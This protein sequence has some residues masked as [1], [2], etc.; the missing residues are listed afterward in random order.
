MTK[1][2][3]RFGNAMNCPCG[4]TLTDE[5][6]LEDGKCADGR[7]WCDTCVLN[8]ACSCDIHTGTTPDWIGIPEV[9][10][11]IDTEWLNPD[12]IRV[13]SHTNKHPRD[14]ECGLVYLD[15]AQGDFNSVGMLISRSYHKRIHDIVEQFPDGN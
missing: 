2:E 1:Q 5:N 10:S 8:G 4:S 15:P 12:S 6:L 3:K 9:K 7:K 13:C 14:C 11:E